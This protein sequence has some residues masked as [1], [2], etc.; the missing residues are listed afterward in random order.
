MTHHEG[1]SHTI[2]HCHTRATC[3]PWPLLPCMRALMASYDTPPQCRRG[4]S[5][6]TGCRL[7]L[8]S[9]N[10]GP[11]NTLVKPSAN[12]NFVPIQSISISSISRASLTLR[13]ITRMCL[14]RSLEIGFVTSKLV[15]LLFSHSVGL[16]ASIFRSVQ[17]CF[18]HINS[19]AAE[20]IA[21]SFASIVSLAITACL[22]D[23][24][25]TQFPYIM[26]VLPDSLFKL[27]V[28]AT[29][30]SEYASTT[31]QPLDTENCS[32]KLIVFYRYLMTCCT[33]N[34]WTLADADIC[35]AREWAAKAKS[36]HVTQAMY[37][38]LP[39]TFI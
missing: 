4:G 19:L 33:A 17:S 22:F 10:A 8:I 20:L 34:Q 21:I 18:N 30:A 1:I 23:L 29:S 35:L 9:D 25:N 12:I 39:T 16:Y 11:G 36:G 32:P 6:S 28:L 15:L 14:E 27:S 5:A 38:M 26:S 13:C 31:P 2:K 7:P 3:T 37:L 24:Q